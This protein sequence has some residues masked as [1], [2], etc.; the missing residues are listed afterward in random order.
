MVRDDEPWIE[1]PYARY[2]PSG[3]AAWSTIAIRPSFEK[4]LGSSRTRGLVS[5]W[6]CTKIIGRLSLPLRSAKKIRSPP[7]TGGLVTRRCVY[8]LSR[9][10]ISLRRGSWARYDSVAAFCAATHALTSGDPTLSSQRYGSTAR[11]PPTSSA[12]APRFVG[13]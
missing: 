6:S 8:A 13:G 7:A 9:S 10:A 2:R 1:T 12:C 11:T 5:A 4:A 3:D